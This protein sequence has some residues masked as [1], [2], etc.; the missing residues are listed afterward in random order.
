[1]TYDAAGR[2]T[3]LRLPNGVV[4][5]YAYD[6]ASRL[7]EIKYKR[8]SVVLGSLLYG[9][10]ASGNRVRVGGTWAR[11]SL[12]QAVSS[13]T[14][15]PANQM[16]T[17][18]TSTLIYD[19]NGNLVND[20]VTT[21]SW[22]ARNRLTSISRPSVSA[23][24]IYDAL[25]RR[26]SKT[27]NG[28]TTDY[29]YDGNDIV[30][31]IQGGVVAATY[32]RGLNIDEPFIRQSSSGNEFYHTDALGSVL[33]LTNDAGAVQT[34][35]RYDP[36]GNTT[37]TGTS[38]NPFQYTGREND[39]TGVYYYRARYY[40]P[41]MQRFISEDPIGFYGGDV[42]F[43]A[44]VGNNPLRWRDPLGLDWFHQD[45]ED[46]V[47]G[48]KDSIIPPGGEISQFLEDNVPA[49]STLGENHDQ[50]VDYL[51]D[52]GVPDLLAN[53]PTMPPAYVYSVGEE[54]LNSG[55]DLLD[56]LFG[57]D[58]DGGGGGGSGGMG[59]RK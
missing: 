44:Y 3:S 36:F 35:Y 12:P 43:Y 37:V 5:E 30:A 28:A 53:I 27:I 47:V 34:T 25:G 16:T 19:A 14:Y 32:L 26:I 59:G 58:D 4:T 38:T 13:T 40:S 31:E 18:N 49:M 56:W 15:N 41:T 39:G 17:F 50:L 33:A 21:Y 11:V 46:Y 52:N 45:G 57:D 20:G 7:T 54:L 42:N 2:R 55:K 48:R 10:D 51:R 6:R 24:F 23:S 9:Y 29:L 22:D 1:L 8:G